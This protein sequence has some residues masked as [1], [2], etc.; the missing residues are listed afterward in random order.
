MIKVFLFPFLFVILGCMP[1]GSPPNKS[2]VSNS[3]KKYKV[4]VIPKST[5]HAY[6]K[7]VHAGVS[8]AA[9]ELGVEIEWKG[10]KG[11]SNAEAQI[12]ILKEMGENPS[13]DAILIA[14]SDYKALAAPI[15]T[16]QKKG[17]PVIIIDSGVE[18][19]YVAY[20]A[21]D[22]YHGGT[23][24][25]KYIAELLGKEQSTVLVL[26]HLP[27]SASTLERERGFLDA[28]K[29]FKNIKVILSEDFV[30]D[31]YDFSRKYVEKMIEKYPHIKGIFAPAEPLTVGAF[32]ALERKNLNKKIKL[33]GYD[34]S[35]AL[36][37]AIHEGKID[38]IML[39]SPYDMGYEALTVAYAYL[40][41][42]PFSKINYTDQALLTPYN[43]KERPLREFLTPE[44]NHWDIQ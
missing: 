24:C 20:I 39:Q 41:N 44:V 12:R 9:L 38:G 11:E 42:I 6:W 25:A 28:I 31:D 8:K 10:S 14:P 37:S 27:Y 5:S 30:G 35:T 34:A 3:N 18:T 32:R 1:S 15:E 19:D 36:I 43:Y 7:N 16:I 13:I 33:V 22:N 2:V 26:R 40:H 21:S 23:H 4:G 29:K 17:K